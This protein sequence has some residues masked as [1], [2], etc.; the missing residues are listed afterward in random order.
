MSTPLPTFRALV[1][2]AIVLHLA[3]LPADGNALVLS[4]LAPALPMLDHA[5]VPWIQRAQTSVAGAIAALTGLTAYGSAAERLS[6]CEATRRA[7]HRAIMAY[8]GVDVS[9]RG[10]ETAPAEAAA[11]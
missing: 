4:T 8:F 3:A 5:L 2:S 1:S 6:R 11:A 10:P 7:Y 9:A